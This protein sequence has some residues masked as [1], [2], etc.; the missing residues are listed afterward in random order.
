[1]KYQRK[2]A[3]VE[4]TQVSV[5]FTHDGTVIPAGHWL[6]VHEDGRAYAA[7]DE[8]FQAEYEPVAVDPT[9]PAA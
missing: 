4:A 1:M 2:P 5:D 3:N 6:V 9:Q 7:T 8:D